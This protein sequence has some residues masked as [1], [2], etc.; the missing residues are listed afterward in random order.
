[1]GTMA[2]ANTAVHIQVSLVMACP[3]I[4]PTVSRTGRTAK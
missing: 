3:R 1:M 2:M 4:V